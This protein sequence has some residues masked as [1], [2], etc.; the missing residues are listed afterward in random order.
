MNHTELV[1]LFKDK[2]NDPS[3][4]RVCGNLSFRNRTLYSYA[5]PIVQRAPDEWTGTPEY[6][7]YFTVDWD[8][9]PSRTT[10]KHL[11]YL[12]RGGLF[13]SL[14][15]V[16]KKFIGTY[17]TNDPAYWTG[18]LR[19][20][21]LESIDTSLKDASSFLEVPEKLQ[22]LTGYSN[23]L[24]GALK[25]KRSIS[26]WRD[27]PP[28]NKDGLVLF[29]SA[30]IR[31]VR[32]SA[33]S[34]ISIDSGSVQGRL[35]R[36]GAPSIKRMMGFLMQDFTNVLCDMTTE[37][38]TRV[39]RLVKGWHSVMK[40]TRNFSAACN[41]ACLLHPSLLPKPSAWFLRESV[42]TVLNGEPLPQ[43]VND[44]INYHNSQKK[45]A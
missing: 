45:A 21:I 31:A 15:V 18:L 27:V 39:E 36:L 41:I 43:E 33:D 2:S 16:G 5:M 40:R 34:Y 24:A 42:G 14:F 23:P 10:R 25:F 9:C 44:Y 19:Q 32:G 6:P 1:Q 26:L 7:I 11:S 22:S 4:S 12:T 20:H 13:S 28:F 35:A 29:L 3:A 38:P 37:A 17:D 30:Y 8:D